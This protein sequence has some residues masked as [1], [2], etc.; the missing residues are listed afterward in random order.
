MLFEDKPEL[1]TLSEE[2]NFLT[3]DIKDE[4]ALEKAI[5]EEGSAI[6]EIIR[7]KLINEPLA[8]QNTELLKELERL[9]GEVIKGNTVITFQNGKLKEL[10]EEIAELKAKNAKLLE[11]LKAAHK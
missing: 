3:K 6:Y 2:I 11:R 9:Q 8:L 7:N 1:K 5:T 10:T 4:E